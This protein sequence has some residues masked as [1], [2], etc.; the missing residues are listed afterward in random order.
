M[1]KRIA[2]CALISL[3]ALAQNV[4][5]NP[6]FELV[7][8]QQ[9][10]LPEDWSPVVSP[11]A[12]EAV[13]ELDKATALDGTNSLKICN[14]KV[15]KPKTPPFWIQD[16][17]AEALKPL[18][19]SDKVE[20][21]VFVRSVDA[22]C[23]GTM[24]FE[25]ATA[26]KVHTCNFLATP[27]SWEKFEL[28]FPLE[29]RDYSQA[30][31]VLKIRGTGTLLLDGAY[32]GPVGQ[33]PFRAEPTAADLAANDYCR[34]VEMPVNSRFGSG[35]VPRK[36]T[37]EG[38]LP[39]SEL[40][41]TFADVSGNIIK[42]WKLKDLPVRKRTT[43]TLVMPRLPD[44]AYEFKFA[45]GT[46]TDYDWFRVG[47]L[48]GRGADFDERGFL[49][50]QGETIF[51]ICNTTPAK[52][53][54]ALRVYSQSGF[55]VF[56][57]QMPVFPQMVDYMT[58]AMAKFNMRWFSWDSW[59]FDA[60]S[61]AETAENLLRL[62]EML[63]KDPSFLGFYTDEP[64]VWALPVKNFRD[65]YK[66]ILR[67]TPEYIGWINHAPRIS[68]SN[69]EPAQSF[70]TVS[71]FSRPA[72]VSG[73]DIYPFPD[74]KIHNNLPNTTISC[75]GDYTEMTKEMT[76]GRKPVW[77]I[78]QAF[79]WNEERGGKPDKN[80]PR[81]G[82]KELRFMAWNAITHGA[83]GIGWYG[84]GCKDVYSEWWPELALVNFEIK[85]LTQK[86]IDAPF[87]Y[88]DNLPSG[89]SGLEGDGF[90]VYVNENSVTPVTLK[91]RAGQE[92]SIQPLD[93]AFVTA[94]PMPVAAPPVFKPETVKLSREYGLEHDFDFNAKWCTHPEYKWG[95]KRTFFAK[96]TFTLDK[97]PQ[98]A[99][100]RVTVD[101][102]GK[103]YLNKKLVGTARQYKLITEYDITSLLQPGENLLECEI[104]NLAAPTELAFE[105]LG[106]NKTIIFSSEETLFSLDGE[107]WVKAFV[108]E[109]PEKTWGKP[110]A[111]V[112]DDSVPEE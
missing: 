66:Q 91:S 107:K 2:L 70:A 85:Y 21:S 57:S 93:V 6:S 5:K 59:G 30:H 108:I 58:E 11:D 8:E 43:T 36:L 110:K 39:E 69:S 22:P 37:I 31:V 45:S 75:I 35:Q 24:F 20:F 76:W 12:L 48:H 34:L 65:Y 47:D 18:V 28:L 53:I 46:L 83:T 44:G 32:L 62:R 102:V 73:F 81:P 100:L 1:L 111:I 26:H 13:Q 77:M 50:N 87:S 4:L 101:D 86:M 19:P 84:R 89:V 10:N 94:E 61:D 17:L 79:S 90:E 95:A 92:I 27:G 105:I 25:S 64:A 42:E 55:N 16:K 68:R 54:D 14:P 7:L 78:L 99:A 52:D 82:A 38:I 104:L 71:R 51:P 41:V 15:E 23:K 3:C 88:L 97:L 112:I 56:M 74:G 67:C 106:D 63:K 96:Q 9:T 49:R 60:R 80:F 29:D 72:D 98:K 109:N 103:L 33:N 40:T